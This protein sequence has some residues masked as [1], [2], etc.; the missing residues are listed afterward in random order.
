MEANK[1]KIMNHFHVSD[2]RY[3]N[4]RICDYNTNNNNENYCSHSESESSESESDG[5]I[6]SFQMCISKIVTVTFGSCLMIASRE[7]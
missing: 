7:A 3:C 4:V 6:P 2:L 5:I 1:Q